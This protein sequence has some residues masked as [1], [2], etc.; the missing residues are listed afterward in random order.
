MCIRDRIGLNSQRSHVRWQEEWQV[1]MLRHLQL[2]S[3]EAKTALMTPM[4]S[5][6]AR[7][8]WPAE[9]RR[10]V[11]HAMQEP[12]TRERTCPACRLWGD[13]LCSKKAADLRAGS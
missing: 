2:R 9:V 1:D 13:D 4:R 12:Q 10:L 5:R 3:Q 8:C 7:I 6:G 11:M